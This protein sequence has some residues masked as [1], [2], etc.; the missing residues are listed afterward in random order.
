MHMMQR[1]Q[2]TKAAMT[3]DLLTTQQVQAILRVD[4][5]TIYRM[6]EDGRLPGIRVGKQ[7]RFQR[8]EIEQWLKGSVAN[9]LAISTQ[10]ESIPTLAALTEANESGLR[11]A[12]PLACVQLIQDAFADM[13]G[14]MIIVTDIQ[15]RPITQP[16][17]AC[18]LYKLLMK[19]VD[20][21]KMC[22]SS[23]LQLAESAS[24]EPR[25]AT[26]EVG[27]LC[28]RGLIHLDHAM[29][30]MVIMGG[31]APEVWP[32]SAQEIVHMSTMLNVPTSL[33]DAHVREV[34]HLSQ[35]EQDKALRSVQRIADIFSH[36]ARDRSAMCGK[37]QAIASL[38]TL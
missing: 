21:A 16:S 4:R 22:A 7:W 17:N 2:Y 11:G 3:P 5:T 29:A 6:V 25:W 15:G 36:I 10:P 24:L 18:G 37:L 28:A 14:V 8:T 30:G 12:L 19:H 34:Y 33:F 1:P 38:T 31:I 35:A 13:L 20:L 23:W 9:P 26:N 27:L 32:P